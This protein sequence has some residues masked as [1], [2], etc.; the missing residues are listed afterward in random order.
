MKTLWI[1]LMVATFVLGTGISFIFLVQRS[2]K[3]VSRLV[4]RVIQA[5][6]QRPQNRTRECRASTA[7]EE[8]CLD[9]PA[10]GRGPP[11][12]LGDSRAS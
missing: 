5:R 8:G 4:E 1:G 7:E 12:W 9:P 2:G 11:E 10:C 6:K 3:A